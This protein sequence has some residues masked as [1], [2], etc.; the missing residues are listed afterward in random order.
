MCSLE[1][2]LQRITQ[3]FGFQLSEYQTFT[4]AFTAIPEGLLADV[5]RLFRIGLLNLLPDTRFAV[6][7]FAYMGPVQGSDI[8]DSQSSKD[9]EHTCTLEHVVHAF[10]L[11]QA[12]DLL[13]SEELL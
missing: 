9:G 4:L 2:F 11:A 3:H 8:G 12:H 1:P 7:S 13:D 5:Y 6:R 10:S